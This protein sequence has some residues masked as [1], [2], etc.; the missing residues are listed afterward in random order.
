MSIPSVQNRLA[1]RLTTKINRNYDTDI[2]VE[3]VSIGFDGAVNL[4]SFF[5]ADHH[6]DTLFYAK[7]F[8]TDL[9]SLGQW[10]DG[11]LF[12]SNTDFEDIFLKIITYEGEEHNS[13]FQFTDKLLKHAEP[14]TDPDVF[15]RI[16]ALK[17][18]N[19]RFSIEDKNHP[20]KPIEF[21]EISL[22]AKEF[23]VIDDGVEL[24]FDG[25]DFNAPDYGMIHLSDADF[26]YDY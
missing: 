9:F 8:K 26:F 15:V 1:D 6:S 5:I 12:F 21:N 3:G 23:Y 14:K 19:G 7:N 18:S 22:Q 20:K 25:L 13:F 10:V 2:V 24:F 11:N 16:D 4:A 17:I